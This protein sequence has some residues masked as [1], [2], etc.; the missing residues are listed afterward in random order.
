[1]WPRPGVTRGSLC[2]SE[3]VCVCDCF[4]QRNINRSDDEVSSSQT[5]RRRRQRLSA[6]FMTA[7]LECHDGGGGKSCSALW[8]RRLKNGGETLKIPVIA[9]CCSRQN[10]LLRERYLPTPQTDVSPYGNLQ[11]PTDAADGRPSARQQHQ[12]QQD[13][14]NHQADHSGVN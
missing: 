11:A 2:V 7:T 8:C 4:A 1:M 5:R 14:H 13:Q 12:H 9:G 6:M 3:C 10:A